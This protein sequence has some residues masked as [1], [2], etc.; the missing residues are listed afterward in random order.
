MLK[1]IMERLQTKATSGM[2]T[3]K[4]A[5][6]PINKRFVYANQASIRADK[7][8]IRA[9]WQNHP[10]PA[11]RALA[12]TALTALIDGEIEQ[13]AL[14]HVRDFIVNAGYRNRGRFPDN[15]P[16]KVLL[17]AASWAAGQEG[18]NPEPFLT[19]SRRYSPIR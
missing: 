10:S 17:A 9:V 18:V 8:T 14:C 1:S 6:Y 2:E 5:V 19:A 16:A 4:T 11:I 13:K 15:D 7:D 12:R 3:V